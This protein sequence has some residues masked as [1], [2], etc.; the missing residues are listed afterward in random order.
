MRKILPAAL[1]AL[2]LAASVSAA[3]LPP[4]KWWRRPEFVSE[5][6][7]TSEQQTR[8]DVIFRLAANELIDLRADAQKTSIALRSELDQPQL[9]RDSLR[10]LAARLSETQGKLFD[11]E[12]MMLVDMRAVLTDDQWSKLRN[13]ID[14]Q[15]PPQAKHE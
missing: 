9:S 14:R 15:R 1:L 3:P 4:G 6:A 8:L 7:L 2:T 13:V 12:V 10:R 5:L 11:R